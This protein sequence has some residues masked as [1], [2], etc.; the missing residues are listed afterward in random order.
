MPQY[1]NL[2]QNWRWVQLLIGCVSSDSR[3]SAPQCARDEDAGNR[4]CWNCGSQFLCF[5]GP[6]P[7]PLIPAPLLGAS[8]D[9]TLV[10]GVRRRE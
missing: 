8:G 9:L 3:W 4:E 7:L 6:L 1:G 10:S 5:A 2:S